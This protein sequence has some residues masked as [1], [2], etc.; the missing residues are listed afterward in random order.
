MGPW[1]EVSQ[2]TALGGGR[3]PEQ[4][5]GASVLQAGLGEDRMAFHKG[6]KR[7]PRPAGVPQ[8]AGVLVTA[9]LYISK[10]RSTPASSK[11]VAKR[12]LQAKECG[13]PSEVG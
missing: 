9:L 12:G 13:W 8:H 7:S 10:S 4:G 5:L 6:A 3:G 1:E 11:E 2:Q